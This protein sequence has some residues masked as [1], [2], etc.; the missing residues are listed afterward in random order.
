MCT[1]TLAITPPAVR[2]E[3]CG[4]RAV[5]AKLAQ[6]NVTILGISPDSVASHQKFQEKLDLPFRLL[7]D[8]EATVARAYGSY[9]PKKWMGKEYMGVYRDTFLY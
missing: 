2:K 7:A 8:T 3:A 4:Y 6:R 5:A 1:F 9:G